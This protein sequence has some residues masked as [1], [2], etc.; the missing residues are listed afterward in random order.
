MTFFYQILS[1]L[2]LIVAAAVPIYIS[3]KNA[4]QERVAVY[5]KESMDF[6]LEFIAGTMSTDKESGQK[7]RQLEKKVRSADY[8]KEIL[9]FKLVASSRVVNAYINFIK[10]FAEG[11]DDTP[12]EK[13][14]SVNK[15]LKALRREMIG[16]NWFNMRT[17]SLSLLRDK[18]Q[19]LWKED[20]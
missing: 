10:A 19:E 7:M 13:L 8:N 3:R 15:L 1:A 16:I 4:R 9:M 2:A 5:R 17:E 12:V 6:I 14:K 11:S 20:K 18:F